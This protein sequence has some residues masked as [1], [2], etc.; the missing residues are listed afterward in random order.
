M[1]QVPRPPLAHQ[2]SSLAHQPSSLAV[3]P[4]TA[5]EAAA[6]NATLTELKPVQGMF[7]QTYIPAAYGQYNNS[8]S[9]SRVRWTVVGAVC[10]D[11]RILHVNLHIRV[12]GRYSYYHL[13]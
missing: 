12:A 13:L 11:G 9:Y 2:P 3:Q 10:G 1:L 4:V 5:T 7:N 6:I 8:K